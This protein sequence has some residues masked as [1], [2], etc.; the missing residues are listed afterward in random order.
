MPVQSFIVVG[1]GFGDESKGST[2]DFLTRLHGASLVVKF[3][4]GCQ[5]AHNVIE[6]SGRHHTF[7]QFGSGTLAGATTHLALGMLVEPFSLLR[8]A[9][10]L[11]E[12]GI[13]DPLS[14]MSIDP[15]C[16]ITTPYHKL[17][18]QLRETLRGSTRHGT[19]GVGIGE[20]RMDEIDGLALRAKHLGTETAVA[21]LREI[22][23]RR[24]REFQAECQHVE[25]SRID[26]LCAIELADHY[27]GFRTYIHLQDSIFTLKG[28]RAPVIFEGSQGILID[29]THGFAPNNTWTDC[30]PANAKRLIAEAGGG[31]T[32]TIGC[33]RAYS[34]RHGAGPFVAEDSVVNFPEAHNGCHPWQGK[35]RQGHFDFIMARYAL[36]KIGGVDELAISHLDQFPKDQ[37]SWVESYKKGSR[38]IGGIL[39][40]PTA[41]QLS[42]CNAIVTRSEVDPIQIIETGLNMPVEY[43][44]YG[45]TAEDRSQGTRIR[46]L[47]P[48]VCNEVYRKKVLR[49]R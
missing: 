16:V 38:L 13:L 9:D 49:K 2:V 27:T 33:L 5:S 1:L 34:T 23:S 39:D 35:F 3:S 25:Y 11:Q 46:E 31:P 48:A 47:G 32:Q 24:M 44:S 45:P 7:S 41:E 21:I 4:G 10:V 30:T 20:T 18:N 6:A 19:C 36:R 28:S 22:K 14:Q 42:Q 15:E 43:V 26:D 29:E 37:F 40:T 17:A 12:K 8:E